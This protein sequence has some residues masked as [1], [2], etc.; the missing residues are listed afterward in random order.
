[1]Y[2]LILYLLALVPPAS[3][4]LAETGGSYLP[5]PRYPDRIPPRYPDRRIRK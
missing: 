2:P 5:L 3:W 1:M 4:I